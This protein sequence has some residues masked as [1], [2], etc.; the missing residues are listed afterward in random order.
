AALRA[1]PGREIA[2]FAMNTGHQLTMFATGDGLHAW[3]ATVT[4]RIERDFPR[5][6]TEA[7]AASLQS[8]IG[9]TLP[10]WLQALHAASALAGIAGCIALY[11]VPGRR[12]H[13]GFGLAVVTL[14]ALVANA[15]IAGGLSG[16][17][18]RYQSR[19]MWLPPFVAALAIAAIRPAAAPAF[20]R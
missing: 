13:T 8:T 4:P 11:L 18:D 9:L 17:Q 1:E 12:R 6:E 15:A 3:P 14:V 19:I 16:P 7:Y 2:A 5:R 20:G 10:D